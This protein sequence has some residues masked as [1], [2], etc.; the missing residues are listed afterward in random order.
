LVFA[1]ASDVI[2]RNVF[3]VLNAIFNLLMMTAYILSFTPI[4]FLSGK[5]LEGAKNASLWSVN[6]ASLL[7]RGKK[8]RSMLAKMAGL[9][10]VSNAIGSMIAGYLIAWIM[11]ENTF[12][13]CIILVFALFPFV[14]TLKRKSLRGIR[15]RKT[16]K[17][18]DIRKRGKD[19]KKFTF[20]YLISG[21]SSGLTKNYILILLLK[22]LG[23]TTET[24]GILLGLNILFLGL[25]SIVTRRIELKKLVLMGGISYS[26][27]IFSL[28]LSNYW[29]AA[30]LILVIGFSR[31]MNR[32]VFEAII[33]KVSDINSY[34]SDVGILTTGSHISQ[35]I[36]LALSGLIITYFGFF[37][38]FSLASLFFVVH[39]ILLYITVKK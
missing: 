34:G 4:D 1:A 13:I 9:S 6:R 3:F 2:G 26:I 28:G 17:I 11:F 7:D 39:F 25:S 30:L 24:I 22:S 21:F 33:S 14:S 31:G 10:N 12:L 23:F 35:A 19:L 36:T 29:M 37:G 15:I 8:K 16:L 20:L 5:I 18:L 38:V 27:L 32:G